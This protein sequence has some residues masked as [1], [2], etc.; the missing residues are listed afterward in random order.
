MSKAADYARQFLNLVLAPAMWISSSL[1]QFTDLGRTIS[2]QS[3]SNN[4]L[5]VPFGP[6]FVI[7]FP[8]FVGCIA[9]GII[10]A[11][12]SNRERGVFRDI[13]WLTAGSFALITLWGYMAAFPPPSVSQWGTALT[14]VPAMLLICAAVVRLR[15]RE[16]ELS[17]GENLVIRWPLSWLAGWCSLA[18]FLNWAQLG[19]HGPI[20][21]GMSET[22]VCLLTL[23]L[24][25]LWAT[26]MLK[27][28]RG[29]RAYVFPIVW[30]LTFLVIARVWISNPNTVIAVAAGI[31]ALVLVWATARIRAY[32]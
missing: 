2:E 30:G 9:Y 32:D 16:G 19:V 29:S 13:G 24:A 12:P 31:G 5:L 3:E 21:L 26:I 25:L 6:A 17:D 1:P 15:N 10:Q 20:G 14:F 7:W 23:A 8:I 22:C 27:K 28:T 4:T 18:V 11:L